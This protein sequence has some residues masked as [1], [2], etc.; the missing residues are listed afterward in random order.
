M[1][2]QEQLNQARERLKEFKKEGLKVYET[3]KEL[4]IE[5]IVKK[6]EED[7]K[8]FEEQELKNGK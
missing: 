4:V 2:N 3:H 8:Y 1:T 7:V 5:M 6:L